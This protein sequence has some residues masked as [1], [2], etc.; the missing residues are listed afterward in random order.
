MAI[1]IGKVENLE[2]AIE[3]V[4]F[5]QMCTTLPTD[6]DYVFKAYRVAVALE[7]FLLGHKIS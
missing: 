6:D 1:V 4:R 3:A 5:I 2:S 7:Q